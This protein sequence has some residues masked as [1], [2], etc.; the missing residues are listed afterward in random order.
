MKTHYQTLNIEPGAT[1]AQLHAKFKELAIANH[2][3]KYPSGSAEQ[4]T[5]TAVFA[6]ITAAYML[7][8]DVKKRAEYD[9]YLQLTRPVCVICEG[10]GKV[11][12]TKGFTQRIDRPC[13]RCNG[14]GYE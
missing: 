1:A 7:L 14:K 5:A 3:D 4:Q 9:A 10:K 12:I 11:Q 13:P 8:K 6:E 2:P